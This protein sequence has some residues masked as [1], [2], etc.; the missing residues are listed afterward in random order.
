MSR[1]LDTRQNEKF[2]GASP[3]ATIE[4]TIHFRLKSNIS[5]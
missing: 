1:I 2:C 3:D 5:L 4:M